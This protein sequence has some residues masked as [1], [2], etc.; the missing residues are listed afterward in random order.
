MSKKPKFDRD[1]KSIEVLQAMSPEGC[2]S[3]FEGIANQCEYTKEH[4]SSPDYEKIMVN[5]GD[6]F[7]IYGVYTPEAITKNIEKEELAELERLREMFEEKPQEEQDSCVPTKTPEEKKGFWRRLFGGNRGSLG[8][9]GS[10]KC[11]CRK[12]GPSKIGR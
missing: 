8:P 4:S 3:S 6:T 11:K 10:S 1:D 12:Y 7:I 5:W 2:V 9:G